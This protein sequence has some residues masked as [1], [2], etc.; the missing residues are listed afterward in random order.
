MNPG[1]PF[2]KEGP[3]TGSEE[4]TWTMEPYEFLVV[5]NVREEQR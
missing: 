3:F 4:G 2:E 5:G 1:V